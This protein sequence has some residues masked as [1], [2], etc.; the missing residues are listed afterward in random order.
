MCFLGDKGGTYGKIEKDHRQQDSHDPVPALLGG[1]FYVLYRTAELLFRHDGDDSGTGPDQE[2]G[3][4]HQHGLFFC[5]RDRAAVK[6]HL[7]GSYASGKD[8]LCR[9]VPGSAHE[10]ADGL[11]RT[12]LSHGGDLGDQRICPGHDLAADHPHLCRDAG[13]RAED[14]ILC[15]YRFLT[16][17]GDPGLLPD[18]RR[19]DVALWLE[20]CV[21]C[22]R[23]LPGR[24]GGCVDRGL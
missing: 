23:P 20:S 18:R 22:R 12:V 9:P 6:R 14:E 16:G 8:D 11:Y 2:P 19:R 3:R 1:I 21:R 7:R 10:P 4:V 5:L 17:G 15:R 13:K 24:H